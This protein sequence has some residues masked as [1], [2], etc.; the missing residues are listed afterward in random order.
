VGILCGYNIN[1]Q[2][3][4]EVKTETVGKRF[5]RSSYNSTSHV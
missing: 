1:V 3:L 2:G 4:K 5:G